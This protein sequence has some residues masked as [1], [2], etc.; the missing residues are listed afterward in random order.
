MPSPV[1][2]AAP[3]RDGNPAAFDRPFVFVTGKGG[4]GKS[5]VAAALAT[6]AAAAGRDT[7]VC[8]VSGSRQLEA[9]HGRTSARGRGAVRLGE[10]MWSLPLDPD[11]ALREWLR[12]Q[13]GGAVVAAALGHSSA[14]AHFVAAAPGARELITIGKMADPAAA[15]SSGAAARRRRAARPR[16]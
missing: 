3:Q 13:P 10:H 9:A 14:F 6:A 16:R 11:A 8:D 5:T 2:A 15:G 4:T 12:R 7:L 1:I